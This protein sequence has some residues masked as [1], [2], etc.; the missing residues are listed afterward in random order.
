MKRLKKKQKMRNKLGHWDEYHRAMATIKKAVAND[1]VNGLFNEYK[2]II[3][4]VCK[5]KD[6]VANTYLRLTYEYADNQDFMWQF[7]GLY[8]KLKYI[9]AMDAKFEAIRY[10]ELTEKEADIYGVD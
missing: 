4:G 2:D 3:Y 10:T 9:K 6:L 5:D 1:K 7:M 8:K